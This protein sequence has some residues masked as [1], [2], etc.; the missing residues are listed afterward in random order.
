MHMYTGGLI[1]SAKYNNNYY[2]MAIYSITGPVSTLR[3]MYAPCGFSGS[4]LKL[5]GPNS[6]CTMCNLYGVH[7]LVPAATMTIYN[8]P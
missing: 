4:D 8:T 7:A 2:T 3:N 5:S 1:S 6:R